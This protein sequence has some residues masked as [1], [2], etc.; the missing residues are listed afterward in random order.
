MK[1][2]DNSNISLEKIITT[3]KKLNWE[4]KIIVIG[5]SAGGL[6]VIDE[7]FSSLRK[8]FEI[9]IV[10]VQHFDKKA[11]LTELFNIYKNLNISISQEK[12][13]LSKNNI[14]FSSPAYHLLLEEEK[15]FTYSDEE[16]VNFSKPSIDVLFETSAE[17]YKKGCLGLLLSGANNDGAK[18]FQKIKKNNGYTI[19][20]DPNSADFPEMIESAIELGSVDLLLDTTKIVELLNNLI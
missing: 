14:Y 5:S 2:L 12:S 1:I 4:D 15:T 11:D 6:K 13:K 8:N 19:G 7:I 10:I 3:F 18:G 16:F 17:V 9:P 20:Q